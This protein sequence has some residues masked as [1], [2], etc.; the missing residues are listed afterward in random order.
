[1]AEHPLAWKGGVK[2]KPPAE[3]FATEVSVTARVKGAPGLGDGAMPKD[4]T[5]PIGRVVMPKS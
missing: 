4:R 1:M 2:P 3:G 5:R